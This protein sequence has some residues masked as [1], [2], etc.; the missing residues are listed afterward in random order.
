MTTYD[1]TPPGTVVRLVIP[2]ATIVSHGDL[3][4]R[5][6]LPG[7]RGDIVTLPLVDEHFHPLVEIQPYVPALEPG[8]TWRGADGTLLH[9]IHYRREPDDHGETLLIAPVSGFM[10]GP[11]LAVDYFGPLTLLA[12]RPAYD[13]TWLPP[14][15]VAP[16]PA[17]PSPV[18]PATPAVSDTVVLPRIPAEESR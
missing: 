15:P 11:A 1:R 9:S 16:E 8:Q 4:M 17:V 13:E 6:T 5:V 7:C 3:Q 12:E 2:E 14:A 10:Y 18:S